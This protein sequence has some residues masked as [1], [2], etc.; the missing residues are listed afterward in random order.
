MDNGGRLKLSQQLR[1]SVHGDGAVIL[2]IQGGHVFSC[3]KVGAR[4]LTL[5]Q[6]D[7][8]LEQL[9]EKI[10]SEFQEPADRVRTDL[11]NFIATLRARELLER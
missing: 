4:I 8:S 3:N 7:I 5:L 10:S 1:I 6:Q 9:T 11:S 2:D